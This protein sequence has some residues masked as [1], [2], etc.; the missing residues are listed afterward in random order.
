ML[1]A[2]GHWIFAISYDDMSYDALRRKSYFACR[3]T[4][5]LLIVSRSTSSELIQFVEDER[6]PANATLRSYHFAY[7]ICSTRLLKA[8]D[9]EVE[10]IKRN[11]L[12]SLLSSLPS[13]LSQTV[14][15][16]TSFLH[17]FV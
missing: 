2:Q 3:S 6:D 10:F 15:I 13:S 16:S 9:H 5:P 4:L 1:F 17:S 8:Y 12:S 14:S 11:S 7:V